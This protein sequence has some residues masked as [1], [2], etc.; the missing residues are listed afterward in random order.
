MAIGMCFIDK[1][2]IFSLFIHEIMILMNII[3]DS[4]AALQAYAGVV[5]YKVCRFKCWHFSCARDEHL[6]LMKSYNAF[7]EI[8]NIDLLQCVMNHMVQYS[9]LPFVGRCMTFYTEIGMGILGLGGLGW[10]ISFAY[11]LG[12]FLA[13]FFLVS[14][15][16]RF[17]IFLKSLEWCSF[18]LKRDMP[19][20]PRHTHTLGTYAMHSQIATLCTKFCS[21]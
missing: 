17:S 13:S 16:I 20:T 10:D 14:S 15:N 12:S 3:I 8:E 6:K 5:K 7:C 21:F 11:W 18:S 9:Y 2:V 4:L 19:L 1:V